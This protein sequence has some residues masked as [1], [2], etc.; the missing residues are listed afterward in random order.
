M[1]SHLFL[2]LTFS[3]WSLMHRVKMS[4]PSIVTSVTPETQSLFLSYDCKNR[5]FSGKLMWLSLSRGQSCDL[6]CGEVWVCM[7]NEKKAS[8]FFMF[9]GN[10]G[11]LHWFKHSMLLTQWNM[12]VSIKKTL[13]MHQLQKL[14]RAPRAFPFCRGLKLKKQSEVWI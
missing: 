13:S 12:F 10:S 3:P 8:S 6:S 2:W 9:Q 4:S 5:C 1:G 7:I 14:T 11:R